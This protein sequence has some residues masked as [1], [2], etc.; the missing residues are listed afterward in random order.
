VDWAVE[1]NVAGEVM[2]ETGAR[3]R[4][5]RRRRLAAG[6]ALAAVALLAGV[7]YSAQRPAAP[8]GRTSISAIV[9]L[10]ARQV[11]P[12]G[13]VVELKD[14]SRISIA[15]EPLVR[16]VDLVNGEAHFQVAKN[17]DRPFVVVIGSVEV[18]AVGT[19]F[20][21]QRSDA[22]VEVLV[23]EGR[24]TLDKRNVRPGEAGAAPEKAPAPT[25]IATLDAGHRATVGIADTGAEMPALAIEPVSEP[26]VSERLSWRI[27]R[28]E[29]TQTPLVEVIE[30]IN[31]HGG[32][33]LSLGDHSLGGVRIS[34]V[35]R[36]DHIETLLR[37][38]DTEDGIKAEH[39][40]DG[41]IVL[42]R[43]R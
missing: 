9:D 40:P 28:L 1:A 22:S 17:K 27:P 19:A 4:R 2:A 41:E 29:F 37:L 10:P 21:V 8:S 33:R 23:T 38:L 6:G 42:S 16:R 11:L 18:R 12:D 14:G 5:R 24:V 26:E 31:Q 7:Y 36:A 32:A 25:T 20:S 35:L 13:S 43:G 34:G 15:F 39:R 3:L 30:M